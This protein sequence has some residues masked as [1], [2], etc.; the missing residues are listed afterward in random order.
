MYIAHLA[1]NSLWFMNVVMSLFQRLQ[2]SPRR[3]REL[4]DPINT[5][6]IRQINWRHAVRR[7]HQMGSFPFVELHHLAAGQSDQYADPLM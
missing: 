7:K 3:I 6:T 2:E 5:S 1:V 4:P